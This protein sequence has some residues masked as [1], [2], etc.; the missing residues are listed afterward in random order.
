MTDRL[1]RRQYTDLRVTRSRTMLG[2]GSAMLSSMHTLSNMPQPCCCCPHT[3]RVLPALQVGHWL[4]LYH[5][6]QVSMQCLLQQGVLG[7]CALLWD[8]PLQLNCL[9]YCVWELRGRVYC[10]Q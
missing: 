9:E 7:H 6:F 4:G 1:Y 2:I 8:H 5:T 3:G 10:L